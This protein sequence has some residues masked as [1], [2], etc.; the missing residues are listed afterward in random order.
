MHQKMSKRARVNGDRI[1]PRERA[2]R[3]LHRCRRPHGNDV[4]LRTG[5][6]E[7]GAELAENFNTAVADFIEVIDRGDDTTRTR[8]GGED[9]L[10]GVEDE[11]ARD[12]HPVVG[13]P[14]YGSERVL[15]EWN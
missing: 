11:Q 7:G 5:R 2:L 13:E 10:R 6:V 9:R 14:A 15:D 12:A 3:E 4:T 8:F 1:R